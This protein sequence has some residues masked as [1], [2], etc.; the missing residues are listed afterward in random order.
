[1][2]ATD[3]GL[4]SC[5]VSGY[6]PDRLPNG[7]TAREHVVRAPRNFSSIQPCVASAPTM[8]APW[9]RSSSARH[10]RSTPI[11]IWPMPRSRPLG[12]CPVYLE[13]KDLGA[14]TTWESRGPT[15]GVFRIALDRAAKGLRAPPVSGSPRNQ[16]RFFAASNYRLFVAARSGLG[17]F[18]KRIG[19]KHDDGAVLEPNPSPAG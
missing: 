9:P 13:S 15:S 1:M 16:V 14:E 2:V 8:L 3:Q 10:R 6:F 4:L 5:V 17:E 11:W 19:I 7:R 18:P 12:Y